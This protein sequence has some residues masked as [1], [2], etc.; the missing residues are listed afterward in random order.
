MFFEISLSTIRIFF[1][2]SVVAR[3]YYALIADELEQEEL[4]LNWNPTRKAYL[5]ENNKYDD[6]V[7]SECWVKANNP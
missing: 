2:Y 3:L 6:G 7:L 5:W 1:D 4:H